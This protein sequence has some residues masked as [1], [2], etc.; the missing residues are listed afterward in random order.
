MR[1]VNWFDERL[2]QL[3]RTVFSHSTIGIPDVA[4]QR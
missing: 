2:F 1:D 3:I 4:R